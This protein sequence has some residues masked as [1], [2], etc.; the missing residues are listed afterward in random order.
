MAIKTFATGEVLTA[1]DTNTYLAN[2]G[3]VYVTSTTIGSA[4][5]SVAVANCFSSTYDN[6]KIMVSGGTGSTTDT[7][8]LT[9]GSTATGYY[10]GVARVTYDTGATSN[11]NDNN[12]AAWRYFG[13]IG[14]ASITMD[15]DLFDPNLTKPTRVHGWWIDPRTGAVASGAG[16]GVLNDTTAYTGFTITRGTAGTTMTGGTITVYG[17]RKA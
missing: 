7:L 11:L 4:V 16:G 5:T 15:V 14:T 17:Y 8:Y 13:V 2:A 3:L 10:A 1:A 9:L 6:Y 12:S